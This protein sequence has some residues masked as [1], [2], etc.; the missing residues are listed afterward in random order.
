MKT[1]I[2]NLANYSSFLSSFFYFIFIDSRY[3]TRK[4]RLIGGENKISIVQLF[5]IIIIV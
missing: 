2:N 3:E 5:P 4:S 1:K